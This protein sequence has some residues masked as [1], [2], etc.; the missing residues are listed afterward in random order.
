MMPNAVLSQH[1]EAFLTLA[2]NHLV[3]LL[4]VFQRY[5]VA[6]AS[7]TPPPATTPDD[8]D[9]VV[10]IPRLASSLFDLLSQAAGSNN[11]RGKN[12]FSTNGAIVQ[13]CVEVVIGWVQMTEEDVSLSNF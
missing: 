2:L 12:W 9:Q 13:K 11:S 5:Y 6:A 1:L 4:P 7:D 10:S 8:P 3:T